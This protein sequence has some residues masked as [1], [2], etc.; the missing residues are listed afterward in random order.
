M[1]ITRAINLSIKFIGTTGQ[2]LDITF[3]PFYKGDKGD[4]GDTIR[5]PKGDSGNTIL[6]GTS[7]P[8]DDLGNDGDFYMNTAAWMIYGPKQDGHWGSGTSLIAR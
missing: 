1:T 5:G 2:E 7:S 6:N 4:P 8:V 3:A